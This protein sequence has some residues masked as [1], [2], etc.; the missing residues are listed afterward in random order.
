MTKKIEFISYDKGA[1]KFFP[2][3]PASKVIPDWYKTL[4]KDVPYHSGYVPL[5][6]VG[7]IKNCIPVR[8]YI[9]GGYVLRNIYE[10]DVK[11]KFDKEYKT[12]QA[13]YPVKDYVSGHPNH[14]CPIKIDGHKHHYFKII[15]PWLIKTPPGYSC[16]IYQPYFWF[17]ESISFFPAIVDTDKH[18]D[19]INLVGIVKKDIVLQPGDPLVIVYPFKRDDWKM[20]SKYHDYSSSTQFK[21]YL[22]KVLHGAYVRFFHS[23]K[24]FL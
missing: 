23:K 6:G 16:M 14:Q 1:A 19:A 13:A 21:L 12:I 10:T 3:L 9:T 2:P 11:V 20:E 5:E 7:S 4:K 15:Q 24:K 8:D 18:P 17:N 22:K